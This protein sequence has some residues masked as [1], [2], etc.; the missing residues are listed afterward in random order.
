LAVSRNASAAVSVS[1]P[2]ALQAD[3][4]AATTNQ[5]VAEIKPGLFS[6]D[7]KI[8]ITSKKPGTIPVP[9]ADATAMD[10]CLA[11]GVGDGMEFE[12][13]AN[14]N[15]IWGNQAKDALNRKCGG[16]SVDVLKSTTAILGACLQTYNIAAETINIR[17][18][19]IFDTEG[20]LVYP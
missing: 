9:I 11:H 8:T 3:F 10:S 1:I 18:G 17:W 2:T 19:Q 13:T 20:K 5:W 15:S 7:Y 14:V 16:T 4:I 6:G 12:R